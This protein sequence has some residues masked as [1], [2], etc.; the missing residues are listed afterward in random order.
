[1]ETKLLFVNGA[2]KVHHLFC[3]K[4]NRQYGHEY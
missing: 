4:R 1:M 2:V 3:N